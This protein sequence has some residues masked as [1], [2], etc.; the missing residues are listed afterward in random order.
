MLLTLTKFGVDPVL[1]L[2]VINGSTGRNNS[3]EHK[4]A[5]FILSRRFDAGFAAS[6]MVKDLTA[7]VSLAA[8]YG[9]SAPL[10]GATLHTCIEA[11]AW[12][13]RAP[14]TLPLCDISRSALGPF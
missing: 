1:A 8:A 12:L 3:T 5:E 11:V 4:Y 7:A 13:P 6:L 14:T 2:E 10:A 9:V